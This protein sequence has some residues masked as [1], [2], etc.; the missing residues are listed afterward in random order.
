[1]PDDN[2]V[3]QLVGITKTYTTI[4]EAPGETVLTGIDLEMEAG[5]TA[6]IVGPSGCGKSTLLNII[7]TLDYPSSG[8]VSLCGRD[9]TSLSCSE[10][11]KVRNKQ[12]G[13]IFQAH[14][15]L[16]QC[17][18]LENVLVPTL[19]FGPGKADSVSAMRAQNLL[20]EVGLGGRMSYR[21]GYLSGG[22]RQRAAVV[23]ALVNNPQLIL[24]DEPTGSLDRDNASQLIDLL[25]H[26]NQEQGTTLLVVTHSQAVA[27]R[28]S[29]LLE[30]RQGKL[31]EVS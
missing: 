26:L 10:L 27:L 30:L 5:E 6:A 29:K 21:P 3:L 15:L 11:E 9:L 19:A 23:R 8:T 20:E 16:P 2:L 31:I 28:M 13:W 12:I 4:G 22:E 25:V 18:V 7:G 24:A 1:M 17:S 14:H